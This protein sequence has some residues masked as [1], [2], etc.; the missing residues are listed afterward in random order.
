MKFRWP[1][2]KK[3]LATALIF[4]IATLTLA[5]LEFKIPLIGSTVHTDPRECLVTLGA[6]LSGPIGGI[7][8]GLLSISWFTPV[9]TSILAVLVA[10]V[11]GGFFMGISYK[12]LVYQRMEL[13]WL[14]FG[15]AG[16]V[17]VYYYLILTPVY[18][19]VFSLLDPAAFT[20][21][22]GDVSYWQFYSTLV[23]LATPELILT[24]VITTIIIAALPPK[25]RCPLWCHYDGSKIAGKNNFIAIRLMTWFLVLSALPLATVAIFILHSVESGFNQV[26]I[27]HQ[28][29]KTQLLAAV[30]S[31]ATDPQHISFFEEQRITPKNSFTLI[32]VN[33]QYLYHPDHSKIGTVIQ[34]DFTAE[35]VDLILSGEAKAFIDVHTNRIVACA[36]IQGQNKIVLSSSD[37]ES[38]NR[39]VS[40][41][42]RSAQTKIA[43]SFFLIA[44]AAG[45]VLWLVVGRPVR[46]ITRFT[47]EVGKGNLDI[48]LDP[49]DA[50]DE[51]QVLSCSFNEMAAQLRLLIKG[52]KEKVME[53]KKTE[54]RLISSENQYRSLNDNIPVG[55][56]RS[57]L[58]GKVIS[59]NSALFQMMAGKNKNA[60]DT[61][62]ADQF[63]ANPEERL[64]LLT[65]IQSKK[66]INDFECQLKRRNGSTFPA[67][68]SARCIEDDHGQVKYIDGIIEDITEREKARLDRKR[69]ETMLR[70]L[71]IKLQEVEETHRKEIARE[72]HDRV[73]QN[74]AVLN[75]NLTILRNQ[76]S[77]E[78]LAQVNT[79]LTDSIDLVEESTVTLR[80]VMAELRP[81]VLDDY[82]LAAS[83]RWYCEHFFKRT[84]IKIDLETASLEEARYPETV[85]TAL[86]RIT[87]EALNNISKYALAANVSITAAQT[88]QC[89]SVIISDDGQ[90]FDVKRKNSSADMQHWGLVNMRE[91]A[92]AL[93]GIF[94]IKSALGKGTWLRVEI[95]LQMETKDDYH[96]SG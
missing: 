93:G 61:I 19:V 52:L 88:T 85:E 84:G 95:P 24:A 9:D 3:I 51:L 5:E 66:Q 40:G 74:L 53:L 70:A 67:S 45:V 16:L 78:Q 8:I 10:H 69:Y 64:A 82:G 76:L 18:I 54:K 75:I 42:F 37:N 43:I 59:I 29:E 11:L 72:L 34:T 91:R 77:G 46:Q 44:I 35:S 81:Q 89:I 25:Y 83:L 36:G 14:L 56:F 6:A 86:F 87:Q 23:K 39:I 17:I 94:Q 92:E 12:K 48:E 4:G 13:P 28:R 73:G 90:G 31:N 50:V 7:L 62:T 41:I 60:T 58:N 26:S 20:L 79:R 32:G 68:I 2:S 30:L 80:D 22:F 33:G 96:F 47:Q 71:S 15:W 21:A 57:T 38:T 27:D 65:E 1:I 55:V 63:Y 49:A